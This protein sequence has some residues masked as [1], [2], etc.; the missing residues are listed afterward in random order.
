M[1]K[2][3]TREMVLAGLFIALG[4]MLPIAFHAVGAGGP[5]FLPMHIPVLMA[6]FVL[7]PVFA[8][9]VGMVTPLLSSVLTGMPPL[10]PMAFIM[11]IELGIYGLVVSLISKKLNSIFTLLTAMV[12][13][14]IAAGIMV[15]ILVNAVGIKFAP[16]LLY[17]KGAVITGVPGMIVQLVFIPVLLALVKRTNP[18]ILANH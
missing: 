12:A 13:G 18:K 3:R 6:G 7:S 17:L 10:M 4:V 14:R 5:V 11:M 15:M 1:R 2:S 8:L 16:P 9:V